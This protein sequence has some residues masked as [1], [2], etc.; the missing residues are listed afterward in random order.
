MFTDALQ[1]RAPGLLSQSYASTVIFSGQGLA[2]VLITITA[3]AL[4]ALYQ[5]VKTRSKPTKALPLVI[6]SPRSI[7][8]KLEFYT[9]Q[10]I[11]FWDATTSYHSVVLARAG[12]KYYARVQLTSDS[13][14]E[15]HELPNFKEQ[16]ESGGKDDEEDNDKRISEPVI[17]SINPLDIQFVRFVNCRPIRSIDTENTVNYICRPS[18]RSR[19]FVLKIFCKA[20][21]TLIGRVCLNKASYYGDRVFS[22]DYFIANIENIRFRCK[23]WN[24]ARQS[25]ST[26]DSAFI[27][28]KYSVIPTYSSIITSSSLSPDSCRI[29]I[30][31]SKT[32]DLGYGHAKL[33]IERISQGKYLTTVAH[34]FVRNKLPKSIRSYQCA[35]IDRTDYIDGECEEENKTRSIEKELSVAGATSSISCDSAKVAK[36]LSNIDALRSDLENAWKAYSDSKYWEECFKWALNNEPKSYREEWNKAA[37]KRLCETF[38]TDN[39]NPQFLIYVL[40][41]RAFGSKVPNCLNWVVDRLKDADLAHVV[42]EMGLGKLLKD[43]FFPNPHKLIPKVDGTLSNANGVNIHFEASA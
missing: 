19:D 27:N 33:V 11:C 13:V 20:T 37:E 26:E 23:P 10:N 4:A 34:I 18:D 9:L 39:P 35:K 30:I 15:V 16:F 21:Y 25:T 6:L 2:A 36:M 17:R 24:N 32:S 3:V 8:K 43:P 7:P 12:N 42:E 1:R 14:P 31:N 38:P 22:F 41:K 5:C 40:G 29:T 28:R